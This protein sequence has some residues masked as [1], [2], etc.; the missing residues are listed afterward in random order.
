MFHA[1]ATAEPRVAFAIGRSAGTA[2]RRNRARRQLRELF[3]AAA[4]D[5]DLV[6]PGDYLIGVQR[7]PFSTEEA[8]AWLTEALQQLADRSAGSSSG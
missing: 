6:R 4:R 1:A 8:R 3:A 7:T 2:V 5:S